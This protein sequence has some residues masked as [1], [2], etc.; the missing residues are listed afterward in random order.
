MYVVFVILPLA[1]K[2][3]SSY[4]SHLDACFALVE[5]GKTEG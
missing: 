4:A 5:A 3:A 2:K 1:N